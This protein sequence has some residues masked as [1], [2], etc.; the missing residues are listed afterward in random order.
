MKHSEQIFVYSKFENFLL[1]HGQLYRIDD[2][3]Y[4]AFIHLYRNVK[5]IVIHY[6]N[7]LIHLFKY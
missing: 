2:N 6:K 7:N 4:P 5:T 1:W 3:A